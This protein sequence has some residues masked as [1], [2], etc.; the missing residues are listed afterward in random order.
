MPSLAAEIRTSDTGKTTARK[1]RNEGKIP[2]VVYGGG[3]PAVS[4]NIDP[5]ALVDM[6]RKSADRNT[7]V[8]LDFSAGDVPEAVKAA[9]AA[10]GALADDG[11]VPCLVRDVQRHPLRR[12]L[13]HVDFFWLAPGQ[14][15]EVMVPLQGV[16]RAKGMA[17]GGRLRLIRRE[18]KIRC[19]WEKLPKTIQ[20]DLT[21]LQIGDMV[22]ASELQLP[23]GASLVARNDFNVLTIY[24]KRVSARPAASADAKK[25]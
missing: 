5:Q 13:L 14:E 2:A 4:L 10:S 3:L 6:F 23:E 17:I 1:I 7:I 18:V 22:K 20:H 12:D 16:G 24:G 9:W 11:T 21:P 8:H 19:A 15:V 25:K